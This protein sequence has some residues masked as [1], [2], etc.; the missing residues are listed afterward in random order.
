[1]HSPLQSVF[2][3]L[4]FVA[5]VIAALLVFLFFR[6]TR[7]QPWPSRDNFQFFTDPA[8]DGSGMVLRED[9]GPGWP[10]R[11][12]AADPHDTSPRAGDGDNLLADLG[13]AHTVRAA[14]EVDDLTGEQLRSIR[15]NAAALEDALVTPG[16]ERRPGLFRYAQAEYPERLADLSELTRPPPMGSREWA[17]QYQC[18]PVAADPVPVESLGR[19]LDDLQLV[20]WLQHLA[21]ELLLAKGYDNVSI[22]F[23][24]KPFQ[25]R[26]PHYVAVTARDPG[27][28]KYAH[29]GFE[30]L[31]ALTEGEARATLAKWPNPVAGVTPLTFQGMPVVVDQAF[32]VDAPCTDE[33]PCTPCYSDSGPCASPAVAKFDA[34]E[35]AVGRCQTP[36]VC[37]QAGR[38][39]D[40]VPLSNPQ[41]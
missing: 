24:V 18:T 30:N 5:S 32:A 27:T 29:E 28:G 22:R 39:A 37:Q 12:I 35:C 13:L 31:R 7:R 40:T 41:A 26:R 23:P 17:E 2:F 20:A 10:H 36:S 15:I 33:R 34:I 1:M 9:A 38:C 14:W 16:L 8:L 25:H 4:L 21:D 11:V 19:N 3:L 6:W